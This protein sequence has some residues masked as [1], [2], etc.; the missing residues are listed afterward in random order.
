MNRIRDSKRHAATRNEEILNR[1]ASSEELETGITAGSLL[2]KIFVRHK[3]STRTM[4]VY[5]FLDG[6]TLEESAR[7][8]GM[9]VSGVR[10]RLSGLRKTLQEI[11]EP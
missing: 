2:S 5:H 4:A 3:E 6:M 11:E 9:S 1:I 10:K 8:T 7:E